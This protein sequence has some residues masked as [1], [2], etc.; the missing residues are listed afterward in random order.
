M[1]TMLLKLVESILIELFLT[2]KSFDNKEKDAFLTEFIFNKLNFDSMR[3]TLSEL[4]RNE[5]LLAL[6]VIKFKRELKQLNVREF[7]TIK[8]EAF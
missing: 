7:E 2:V 6:S 4:F 3:V 1:A 8:F 5:Q